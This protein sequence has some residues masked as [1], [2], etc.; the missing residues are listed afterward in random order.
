MNPHRWLDVTV[1]IK[2]GM[3]HWPHDPAVR[4]QRKLDMRRGDKCN[5]SLISMGSHTGTHMDPP[6]HFVE[7]GTSLDRMPLEAGIGP[8]RIVEIKNPRAVTLDELRLKNIRA[9]ERILFKTK[10]SARCWKTDEFIKDFVFI[11]EEAA[12]F[13]ARKKPLL[14]GVDYLSVGG[15]FEDGARIHRTLLKAGIW[16]VEGLNLSRVREGNHELICLPLKIQNSDGA[17]CRAVL[18]PMKGK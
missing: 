7:K 1:T 14:V 11:A 16:I 3:V 8:A 6:F 5:V 17:S 4:I 13:L 15:F 2:D 12:E 9:G 18:R 10:N